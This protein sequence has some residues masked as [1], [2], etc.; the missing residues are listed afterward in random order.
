[1]V[2][3][4]KRSSSLSGESLTRALNTAPPESGLVGSAAV[5]A[6]TAAWRQI[7][8]LFLVKLSLIT[9]ITTVLFKKV[10]F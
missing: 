9:L 8:I 3:P 10:N 5:Q 4:A 2:R 1:M 7:L 6:E